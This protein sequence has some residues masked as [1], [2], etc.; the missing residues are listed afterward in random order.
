LS[1]ADIYSKLIKKAQGSRR[2]AQGKANQKSRKA[3]GKE[4][5]TEGGL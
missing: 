4:K 5:G 3:Q 2:R 1:I